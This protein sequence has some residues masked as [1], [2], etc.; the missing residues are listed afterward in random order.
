M[1]S[2]K[3]APGGELKRVAIHQQ[4]CTLGLVPAGKKTQWSINFT[5]LIS[6]PDHAVTG[7]TTYLPN[8]KGRASPASTI[9]AASAAPRVLLLPVSYIAESAGNKIE[10]I[11]MP[12]ALPSMDAMPPITARTMEKKRKKAAALAAPVVASD[13]T[14]TTTP[15]PSTAPATKKGKTT[16]NGGLTALQLFR[17]GWEQKTCNS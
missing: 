1:P 15:T 12:P 14:S 13:D 11:I 4:H 9:A 7:L 8:A 17:F 10:V 6:K 16:N 2:D 5:D 3:T